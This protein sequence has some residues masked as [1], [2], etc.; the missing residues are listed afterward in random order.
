MK[1]VFKE[2]SVEQTDFENCVHSYGNFRTVV[3][4]KVDLTN[5]DE[6]LKALSNMTNA[7]TLGIMTKVKLSEL[8]DKLSMKN[9][10]TLNAEAMSDAEKKVKLAFSIGD[11]S[12]YNVA[13][14]MLI[15]SAYTKIDTL[16]YSLQYHKK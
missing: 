4:E 11:C 3:A 6:I 15:Q 12:F 7:M 5:P 13:M 10:M 14:E 8:T 1:Q 16:K 2:G 9:L